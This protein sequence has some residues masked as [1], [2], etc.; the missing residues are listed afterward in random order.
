MTAA[1]ATATQQGQQQ[2]RKPKCVL[3]MQERD[4]RNESQGMSKIV[5]CIE[6]KIPM[7]RP[8]V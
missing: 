8:S 3:A 6:L 4:A 7:E 1:T 2:Q 5:Q